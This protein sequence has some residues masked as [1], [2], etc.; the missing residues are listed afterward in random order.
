[1]KAYFLGLFIGYVYAIVRDGA[2]DVFGRTAVTNVATLA[3]GFILIYIGMK[4][5][6][7]I[8]DGRA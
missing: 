4:I 5:V 6:E 3:L 8:E 2:G 1:M 7:K